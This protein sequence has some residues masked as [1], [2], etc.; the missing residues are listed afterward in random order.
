[1]PNSP[2][3][4]TMFTEDWYEN[5]DPQCKL[6]AIIGGYVRHKKTI[7]TGDTPFVVIQLVIEQP[8]FQVVTR[9]NSEQTSQFVHKCK[10]NLK[11]LSSASSIVLS[12]L[13]RRSSEIDSP[14]PWRPPSPDTFCCGLITIEKPVPVYA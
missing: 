10:M 2:V 1:M 14:S 11:R 6:E 7:S 5:L 12:P 13:S 3:I 8:P 9:R 4:D